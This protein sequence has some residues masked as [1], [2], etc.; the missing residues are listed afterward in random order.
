MFLA[1][2]RGLLHS[3]TKREGVML[4]FVDRAVTLS[5]DPNIF[6]V[7]SQTE[8]RSSISSIKLPG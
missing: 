8:S 4:G 3:A 1:G 5:D 6:L 2:G 7:H